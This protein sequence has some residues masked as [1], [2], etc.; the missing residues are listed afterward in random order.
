MLV[1]GLEVD[2]ERSRERQ[3]IRCLLAT[4][5]AEALVRSGVPFRDAHEQVAASV[6]DGTFEKP[7]KAATRESPGPGGI[8]AALDDARRRFLD[9][10]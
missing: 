2:A 3:P 9:D 4:D 10:L 1:S 6:R 7:A 8:H 5:V